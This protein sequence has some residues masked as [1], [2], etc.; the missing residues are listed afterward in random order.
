MDWFS[1][2]SSWRADCESSSF[3][4]NSTTDTLDLSSS[5]SAA[6]HRSSSVFLSSDADPNLASN[7]SLALRAESLSLLASASLASV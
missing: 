5:D 2:P 6:K 7:S 3:R 1:L 4:L